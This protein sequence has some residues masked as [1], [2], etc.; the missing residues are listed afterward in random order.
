MMRGLFGSCRCGN[1][2]E[3]PERDICFGCYNAQQER[4]ANNLIGLAVRRSSGPQST[5]SGT[6]STSSRLTRNSVHQ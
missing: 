3:A 5:N 4:D 1:L 6:F 2:I